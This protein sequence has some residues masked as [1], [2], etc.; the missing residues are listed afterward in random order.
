M[1]RR[2]AYAVGRASCLVDRRKLLVLRHRRAAGHQYDRPRFH[3]KRRGSGQIE[4]PN[5]YELMGLESI[6]DG[7]IVVA[8]RLKRGPARDVSRYSAPRRAGPR[9]PSRAVGRRRSCGPAVQTRRR[10]FDGAAAM[11]HIL[12]KDL[13]NAEALFNL[14]CVAD[15][16]DS[17][18]PGAL[19]RFPARI[20]EPPLMLTR[21][22]GM[23]CEGSADRSSFTL[24]GQGPAPVAAN[25]Q[26][27]R[28][29]RRQAGTTLGR[30]TDWA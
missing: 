25:W 2:R 26:L 1:A 19:A 4:T 23:F 24:G 16:V 3:P 28:F 14:G 8:S 21:C 7:E 13:K 30:C 17:R 20:S 12:Q 27:P 11:E 29:P 10:H 15:F 5:A 9:G 6:W 18:M 22:P